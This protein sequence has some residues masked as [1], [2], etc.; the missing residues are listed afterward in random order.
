MNILIAQRVGGEG[1]HDSAAD[2]RDQQ[3]DGIKTQAQA[4]GD[5]TI[6]KAEKLKMRQQIGGEQQAQDR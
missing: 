3:D 4:D 1:R 5:A 6:Q 2:D